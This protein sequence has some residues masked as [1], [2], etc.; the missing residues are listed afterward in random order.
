MNE[1]QNRVSETHAKS[2][3]WIFDIDTRTTSSPQ[4]EISSR[5]HAVES[6]GPG[7]VW[8]S[9]PQWL[10][11]EPRSDGPLYWV[12]GKPGSGKSTL[13]KFIVSSSEVASILKAPGSPYLLCSHYFWRA[14]SEMQCSMKGMLCSLLHQI[15]STESCLSSLDALSESLTAP[16]SPTDWSVNDL[17]NTLIKILLGIPANTYIF[18]DGLDEVSSEDGTASLLH[19]LAD[20][21]A[22]S[23]TKI[24][25]SSRPE[26]QLRR[27]LDHYPTV[28]LHDLTRRD[29]HEYVKSSLTQKL[30][31][32]EIS[33]GSWNDL[34]WRLVDKSDGVFLWVRLALRSVQM[35]I[36]NGDSPKLIH[37]RTQA[38]PSDLG[39]LYNDMWRRLNDDTIIYRQSA[40]LYFNL[41]VLS[42]S[43][44]SARDERPFAQSISILEL[45]L[46][47]HNHRWDEKIPS[48]DLVKKCQET[49]QHVERQCA[50]ILEVI[51]F[52]PSKW[53]PITLLPEHELLLRFIHTKVHFMHRT[54]R[55]FLDTEAGLD[56]LRHDIQP[57]D[58][59]FLRL[60]HAGLYND[61]IRPSGNRLSI[62]DVAEIIRK[63]QTQSAECTILPALAIL[64]SWHQR[65]YMA[66]PGSHKL[67]YITVLAAY[68]FKDAVLEELKAV[69]QSKAALSQALFGACCPQTSTISLATCEL[70][71][72]LVALGA[73]TRVLDLDP[74][75]YFFSTQSNFRISSASMS[76]LGVFCW[77]LLYINRRGRSATVDMAEIHQTLQALK[78][79]KFDA[80]ARA[81]LVLTICDGRLRFMDW[82]QRGYPD[83]LT[84][85]LSVN[86]LYLVSLAE[87]RCSYWESS[88]EFPGHI[89]Q[90]TSSSGCT[91]PSMDQDL[92]PRREPKLNDDCR[93]ILYRYGPDMWLTGNL[94][95]HRPPVSGAVDE[96]IMEMVKEMA[97]SLPGS[98]DL[99]DHEL[100]WD[101]TIYRELKG[102]RCE[103]EEVIDLTQFDPG[104]AWAQF[105]EWGGDWMA[106]TGHCYWRDKYEGLWTISTE[107]GP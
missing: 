90:D 8:P 64:K 32:D 102:M 22:L 89:Y 5:E 95:F 103:G 56:I 4:D 23:S 40:S 52:E 38:L 24:C 29:I 97:S 53:Q 33:R 96:R 63:V 104:R 54:A 80:E 3:R 105:H 94:T 18:L 37:A 83:G 2:F 14:G 101:E 13:M 41:V 91:L 10:S 60:Y 93:I 9:F 12:S 81:I 92:A 61:R 6:T 66:R 76:P 21:N 27:L 58:Q 35:G 65:C 51:P 45:T 62:R 16:E 72:K 70:I 36:D 17:R 11:A 106:N 79:F 73:P 74:R 88:K 68:G 59:R 55:D 42:Q 71:R 20:I 78:D 86:M 1:R 26:P 57:A 98:R 69:G 48:E 50:G 25:I 75:S 15:L 43:L 28:K 39:D 34:V 77:S 7:R 100:G 31:G 67:P 85:I 82:E 47:Y 19:L 44:F 49:I 107:P 84:L 46:A 30:P 99:L 87:R